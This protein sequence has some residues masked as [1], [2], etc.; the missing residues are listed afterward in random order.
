MT[1]QITTVHTKRGR[2]TLHEHVNPPAD[3]LLVCAR[4]T[5]ISAFSA[6]IFDNMK[7]TMGTIFAEIDVLTDVYSPLQHL[8]L[9]RVDAAGFTQQLELLFESSL[10]WPDLLAFYRLKLCAQSTFSVLKSKRQKLQA[11]SANRFLDLYPRLAL[12][13]SAHL[14]VRKPLHRRASEDG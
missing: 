1:M 5:E 10:R 4:P 3:H 11:T 13:H 7:Q 8:R 2:D 12:R 14:A 9:D 6:R